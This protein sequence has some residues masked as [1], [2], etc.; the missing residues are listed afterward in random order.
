MGLVRL[1]LLTALLGPEQFGLAAVA[2][3]LVES[4]N[5]MA[6]TGFRTALIQR[7]G[8]V[9]GH[10]DSA[11]SVLVLRGVLLCAVLFAAAS[12]AALA[13]HAPEAVGLV[14]AVALAVL[15]EAFENVGVVLLERELD[16]RR[17]A[18]HQLF[19][20]AVD[21]VASIAAALVL[22]N[23]WAIP[24][25][26][27]AGNAARV[28]TSYLVHPYRPRLR[29]EPARI[30]E[31]YRF[32]RW[33][34]LTNLFLFLAHRGDDLV[35][36]ALL[37]VGALGLYQFAYQLA[38][39]PILELGRVAAQ[40]ALPS[41]ARL[42]ADP[43]ALRRAYFKVVQGTALL[44]WPIAGLVCV[45]ARDFT[46]YFLNEV[47]WPIAPL[48]EILAVH[49]AVRAIG[50][51]AGPVLIALGR[52]QL[53][54][55]LT[56]IKCA[57]IALTIVPL[58]KRFGLSGVALSVLLAS[59]VSNLATNAT[60]IRALGYRVRELLAL[61]AVPAAATL[62]MALF[63]VLL[64]EAAPIEGRADLVLHGALGVYVY[65]LGAHILGHVGPHPVT[66]WVRGVLAS[67]ALT[68]PSGGDGR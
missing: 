68:R 48:I 46:H 22:R 59:I 37:G 65:A 60:V 3:L 36:S 33:L 35:V 4:L 24:I 31:L 9:E 13:L 47:W 34:F 28:V 7:Q 11:F 23:A 45:F 42:R 2:L 67:L 52:P 30:R 40:V 10:L 44:S 14:R 39:L 20:T 64:R 15:L 16:F 54:T 63:L 6:Q 66:D 55:A 32:G 5:T 1:L 29:F 62:S 17:L 53:G 61:F 19:G 58:A 21:L 8:E 18:F 56:L 27:L 38:H 51:T 26:M 57:G 50:A 49:A 41:Y 25:G 12:P 43:V